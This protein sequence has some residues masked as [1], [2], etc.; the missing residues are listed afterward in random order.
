[1]QTYQERNPAC[2]AREDDS[3]CEQY[4][5]ETYRPAARGKTCVLNTTT[6]EWPHCYPYGWD[7]CAGLPAELYRGGCT[8][9]PG[10]KANCWHQTNYYV[11]AIEEFTL[12]LSHAIV[13]PG[14]PPRDGQQPHAGA[15]PVVQWSLLTP[16]STSEGQDFFEIAQLLSGTTIGGGCGVN[17]DTAS[18]TKGSTKSLRYDELLLRI[19]YANTRPWAGVV[20]TSYEYSLEAVNGTKSRSRRSWEKTRTRASSASA[21]RARHAHGCL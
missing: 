4:R 14:F 3:S 9:K 12:L 18:L 8:G 2:A 20:N 7:Q 1:M 11:G 5:I 10:D 21:G 15:L 16:H 13:V 17:L 6:N 19:T